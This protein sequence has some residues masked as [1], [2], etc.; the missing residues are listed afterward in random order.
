MAMGGNGSRKRRGVMR[1]PL[2]AGAAGILLG[3]GMQG[4]RAG[5]NVWNHAADVSR[6]TEIIA[7]AMP[8]TPHAAYYGFLAHALNPGEI[9]DFDRACKEI[10]WHPANVVTT[11]FEYGDLKKTAEE[12]GKMEKG[13]QYS[14]R[15]WIGGVVDISQKFSSNQRLASIAEKLKENRSS[16]APPTEKFYERG[17]GYYTVFTPGGKM[18]RFTLQKKW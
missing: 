10:G 3:A 16:I 15:R 12:F 5:N 17:T 9:R 1:N 6:R 14:D 4:Q 18:V 2:V 8:S 13:G 11:L 7:R